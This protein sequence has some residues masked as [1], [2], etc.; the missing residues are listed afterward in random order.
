[1]RDLPKRVDDRGGDHGNE[2]N[3]VGSRVPMPSMVLIAQCPDERIRHNDE[4]KCEHRECSTHQGSCFRT[5]SPCEST[6][7]RSRNPGNPHA[8]VPLW[9]VGL[10]VVSCYRSVDLGHRD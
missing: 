2:R 7:D 4:R 6:N 3:D 10:R 9:A 5:T 8:D 1:M